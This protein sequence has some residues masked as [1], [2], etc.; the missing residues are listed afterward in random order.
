MLTREHLALHWPATLRSGRGR[1]ERTHSNC[2]EAFSCTLFLINSFIHRFRCSSEFL[3]ECTLLLY[4][5]IGFECM[6]QEWVG[7]PV[8]NTQLR[9]RDLRPI[10]LSAL[11]QVGWHRL[12]CES[13]QPD[14]RQVEEPYCRGPLTATPFSKTPTVAGDR[15]P[16][17]CGPGL[18]EVPEP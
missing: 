2:P 5:E 3:L 7:V 14:F 6:A 11:G 17:S 8:S 18:T 9:G 13:W 10:D 15:N 4:E 1:A 12:I 16:S